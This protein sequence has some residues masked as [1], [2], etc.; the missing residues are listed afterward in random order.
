MKPLKRR[1]LIAKLKH[2]GFEGPFPGGKHSY[3]KRGS[4]KIRIPNEHGTDISEDLL[5]RIL[6][7]AGISKEEWDRT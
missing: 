1:E 5:Q 7:Q 4:L 2:F 3:M 6:K